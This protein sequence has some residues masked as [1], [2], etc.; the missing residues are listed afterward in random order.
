MPTSEEKERK[1]NQHLNRVD[2]WLE[3]GPPDEMVSPEQFL[4]DLVHEARLLVSAI[5]TLTPN[6]VEEIWEEVTEE[7]EEIEVMK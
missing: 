7:E 1:I 6:D 4:R 5:E 3:E 2:D